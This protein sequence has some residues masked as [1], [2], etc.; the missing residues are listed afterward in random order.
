MS[1]YD[2]EFLGDGF[3][4]DVLWIDYGV[5]QDVLKSDDLRRHYIADY[6][7]CSL[8]MSTRNRQRCVAHSPCLAGD[9]KAVAGPVS[10]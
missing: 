10:A 8:V 7:H 1:G 5:F 2:P 6:P 4:I 9:T 3:T